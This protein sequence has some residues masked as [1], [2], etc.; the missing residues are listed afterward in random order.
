MK[1]K[2]LTLLTNK[3]KEM[4][5]FYKHIV[6][7]KIIRESSNSFTVRIGSTDLVFKETESETDPF[8]HFAMNIPENKLDE[9]KSWLQK[10]IILNTEEEEDEAFFKSWNAHAIY[11]EDPSGNILEFI[12]RHNLKNRIEHHFSAKDI[13]TISEIGIVV[14]EVIPFVRRLNHIGIPNWKEDS[15]GLTPVG[16]EEGLFIIVKSGRRWFFSNQNA[17]FCPFQVCIDGFGTLCFS[18]KNDQVFLDYLL[19]Q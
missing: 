2:E 12:A 15:E 11:F 10:K 18:Q 7:L 13:L 6:E 5:D 16:G 17:K 3:L 8:Y 9:A 1:I 19:E 4:K 14:D